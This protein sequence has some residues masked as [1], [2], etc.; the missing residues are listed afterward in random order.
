[1][2]PYRIRTAG[3]NNALSASNTASQW[4][5]EEEDYVIRYGGGIYYNPARPAVRER[6]V[7]GVRE[8]AENYDLDGIHF[9]DYFY[10]SPDES[11]DSTAYREYKNGGGS[12]SL[13]DTGARECQ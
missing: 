6:I 9:D 13:G 4:E 10:P 3:N 7:D 2:N 8:L 5:D 12:L 11:F 1:M